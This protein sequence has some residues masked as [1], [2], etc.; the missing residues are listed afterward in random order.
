M[1]ASYLDNTLSTPIA[2]S[3]S[4]SNIFLRAGIPANIRGYHYLKEAVRLV[5]YEP[6]IITKIT[7]N[8]YPRIAERYSTSAFKV[9]RA[10]RHAI[11]V[12]WERGKFENFN[13]MFGY[14]VC[15]KNYKLTN[16]ELIALIAEKLFMDT[17][18]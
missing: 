6:Q 16:S 15:E 13:L 9:E 11:T 5:F 17:S 8:L 3:N 14:K 4:I 12:A 1:S 18:L 10:I 7:K 2:L